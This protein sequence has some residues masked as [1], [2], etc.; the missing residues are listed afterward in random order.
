[1]SVLDKMAATTKKF[2]CLNFLIYELMAITITEASSHKEQEKSILHILLRIIKQK[3]HIILVLR[4]RLTS[5]YSTAVKIQTPCVVTK[6]YA[7]YETQQ[8][9]NWR[10]RQVLTA[11]K[12]KYRNSPERRTCI[13]C[14]LSKCWATNQHLL[15][16]VVFLCTSTFSVHFPF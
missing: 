7:S 3:I 5:K 11:S 16:V 2:N 12:M 9:V 14:P 10:Q 6:N 1:M 4:F 15:F 13:S 8:F